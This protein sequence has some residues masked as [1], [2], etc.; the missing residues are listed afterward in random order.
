MPAPYVPTDDLLTASD[1]TSI[2]GKDLVKL[3]GDQD[4]MIEG[5]RDVIMDIPGKVDLTREIKKY[6]K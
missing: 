4:A 5:L 6:F 1:A 3:K 2:W